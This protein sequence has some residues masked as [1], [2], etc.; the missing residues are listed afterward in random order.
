[1]NNFAEFLGSYKN[2][3]ANYFDIVDLIRVNDIEYRNMLNCSNS[4]LLSYH[5]TTKYTPSNGGTKC[6]DLWSKKHEINTNDIA[7]QEPS[8]FVNV[9][10]SINNIADLISIT[11]KFPVDKTV[12]YNINV[13][14]LHII[15]P[16]LVA[17]NSMIGMNELKTNVLDQVLYFMQ[18]MHIYKNES[19]Y[20]HT[21]LYGPPGTGK[22]EVAE[23]VGKMYSKMGILKKNIFRKVTRSDLIAGYLGQTALK[24]TDVI[25]SCI[26][27]C[28]FIDE[29]Y[30]L[31]SDESYSRECIDTLN[32]CLSRHKN[33]L[34]VIIAGYEDDIKQQ[35]FSM[36][37]GLESRFI[38]RFNI[39]AYS[40]GELYE[41]FRKKVGDIEWSVADDVTV[42]W[43]DRNKEHFSYYGRDV[44]NFLSHTK[45]CHSRRIFGKSEGVKV[46]T[47]LDLQRG[48]DSFSKNKKKQVIFNHYI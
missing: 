5:I 37:K 1:M 46:I 10:C 31:G 41:I 43:F 38:W 27:G 28:L 23:I 16:E 40:P 7:I 2:K 32:E 12:Q 19:D 14:T 11:D 25:N 44:E 36:N 34:M 13:K 18:N 4:R 3:N 17:L 8:K 29:V 42:K 6:Y 47:E 9:D 20:K 48:L 24:T 30:A 21:V 33:N 35:F 22:T 26:G 15:R 39:D 45:V